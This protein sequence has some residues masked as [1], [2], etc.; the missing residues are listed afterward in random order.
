LVLSNGL[1]F[2]S[3]LV[4]VRRDVD[5]SDGGPGMSA[6]IDDGLP[7]GPACVGRGMTA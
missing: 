3:I 1:I 2:E 4:T 7:G 5:R 6:A